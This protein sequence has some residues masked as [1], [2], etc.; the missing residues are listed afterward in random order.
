MVELDRKLTLPSSFYAVS[1]I[2]L[3]F[4]F[5]YLMINPILPIYSVNKVGANISEVAVIVALGSLASAL[6]KFI[7]GTMVRVKNGLKVL[8][9]G[10]IVFTICNYLYLEALNPRHLMI[11][12]FLHG[13]SFGVIVTLALSLVS[14][15][16][17]KG[18]RGRSIG[19][20]SGIIGLGLMAGPGIGSVIIEFWS[21]ESIFLILSF[22]GLIPIIL[23]LYLLHVNVKVQEDHREELRSFKVFQKIL[24]NPIVLISFLAYLI[25]SIFF[26]TLNTFMPIYLNRILDISA[27]SVS[28]IFFGFFLLAALVRLKLDSIA[29][30]I[31]DRVGII[32][33]FVTYII[34][35]LLIFMVPGKYLVICSVVLMGLSHGIIFPLLAIRISR[36]VPY[37]NLIMAN[38][39]FLTAFDVGTFIGPTSTSI[40]AE[41][42][43]IPLA[44]VASILPATVIL[45]FLLSKK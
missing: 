14:F 13:I 8:L 10:L 24:S 43:S 23:T 32:V 2:G 34:L 22:L 16:A 7:T 39:I 11:V 6:S 27:Q 9:F 36:T 42:Y 15:I 28:A 19:L 37:E 21:L 20:Y 17:G 29:K 1:I 31:E 30:K 18:L 41:Y 5:S 40:L 44:I 3:F 26:G 12:R 38:A 4:A 33:G 35:S 45:P 25:Y